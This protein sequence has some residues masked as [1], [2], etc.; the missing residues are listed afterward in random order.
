[1]EDQDS[2]GP[3]AGR[4]P[5]IIQVGSSGE[6]WERKQKILVTKDTLSQCFRQFCYQEAK[7]P[8]EVCNRLHNLC[9]QWLKPDQHTKNEI[10]DL[11]ILEQFLII[12]P[13]EIE[14]WV[15]ECG[16]ETSSQAVALAEGF[17]LSRAEDKKQA[18]QQVK[19][20]FTEA[21]TDSLELQKPLLDAR[22]RPLHRRD[23]KESDGHA[24][25]LGNSMMSAG[26]PQPFLL[27]DRGEAA[28]VELGQGPGSFEEFSVNFT[29]EEWAL[30]NPD[31]RALYKEVMEE[32]CFKIHYKIHT[33]E[34]PYKCLECGKSFCQSSTLITH[35][36][37]HTGEKPYKCLECGKSFCQKTNLATHKK[38]HM[39]ES[40]HKCF[41][42]G[43]SFMQKTSL[44]SH[45]RIHTGEKPHKCLE[46]G[47]SFC[48]KISLVTHQ[49]IHTKEKLYKCFEC[50]KSFRHSSAL[51][52][53]QRIHTGEKPY[54]CLECGKTF[55]HSSA[56]VT[57]QRIH[58][59]KKPYKCCECGKSFCQ[60]IN[61]T[62]HQRIHTG[63]KP[64]KCFECGKS[65]IQRAYLTFHQRFHTGEKPHK[66]FQCGKGF[67]QKR[68]LT[69]HQRIHTG[70]KPY[71]CLQCE[72]T[73]CRKTTLTIHQRIHT[74]EKPHKCLE[75]GKSFGQKTHLTTHQ[76]IHTGEKPHKCLECGKSF[77]EKRNLATHQRIHT[78]EKPHQCLQ[79]G[80]SFS[81]KTDLT[82]H[83]RIHT[84]EKPYKCL[85]CGKSFC[86]KTNLTTHQRIHT[87]EKPHKCSECGK[88]FTEKKSLISH[89]RIHTGEKP[90]KCLDCGK[91][92]SEKGS[93]T[94][95]QRIHT[96]EKLHKCLECGKSF[97]EKGSLT[98]H[99]LV[100][101]GEK[102]HKCLECG[103]TFR[104][105]TNL[106]THQ[107][108][109]TGEKPHKC[110]ECGKS[111]REKRSLIS[112]QQIHTG[113]KPHKCLVGGESSCDCC[114]LIPRP[115]R[116]RGVGSIHS[117]TAAGE[118]GSPP[119]RL[120]C[121]PASHAG[122]GGEQKPL[123]QFPPCSE[124]AG[125]GSKP[126]LTA[127]GLF[128]DSVCIVS[129][130]AE[131]S[132]LVG[133][134]REPS[135][136]MDIDL[137][138]DMSVS[139]VLSWVKE[140]DLLSCFPLDRSASLQPRTVEN[141]SSSRRSLPGADTFSDALTSPGRRYDSPQKRHSIVWDHFEM[142]VDPSTAVCRYCR[143]VMSR[144]RDAAH[145][146]TSSMLLHL[147]RQH[148]SVLLG[149]EAAKSQQSGRKGHKAACSAE[150]RT[151]APAN[152]QFPPRS[153]GHGVGP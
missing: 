52:I 134:G 61:L 45:Q 57:H 110:L 80:R 97:I 105:K 56:L 36:R 85:K 86:R 27:C 6:F 18:E 42:C 70:E 107:R 48:Q 94:T 89:Q 73:F 46:C 21:A 95:H 132:P 68:D 152:S 133:E 106:T 4:S 31:Q 88:S 128:D 99:Q 91:C 119:V 120:V 151:K 41:E 37:I 126:A 2:D 64:H 17:L 3:E 109:H 34:K 43:K 113:G 30:L 138:G 83:Q 101:T 118:T 22:E 9:F 140:K 26:P 131:A 108:I 124:S 136:L 65:F 10:L 8:R 90:H 104:R 150:A 62:S 12:L 66:C 47:K 100:H 82:S 139:D 76:R 123:V 11:V 20:L 114:G 55:R 69:I 49:R 102:P 141:S 54:K 153:G 60:K 146:S 127:R 58:S 59:G 72:K 121:R 92:F 50:E 35:Q 1:M 115:V 32:N 25:S 84:G 29:E 44:I 16:A 129:N 137:T 38:N 143:R 135:P 19:G 78:G 5:Y 77:A 24:T 87:G 93:L 51:I 15:R 33:G 142:G 40:P 130:L 103:K 116:D 7:G 79:C 147:K 13:Q 39:R 98:S 53:H 125:S 74:G 117:I 81:Q 67:C 144:G 75:C 14:S 63:G 145:Y 28:T 71:K 149:A 148:Q 23:G 111:F 112:H 122:G 96:G